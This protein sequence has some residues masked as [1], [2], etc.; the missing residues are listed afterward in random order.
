MGCQPIALK[1]QSYYPVRNMFKNYLI[2]AWREHQKAKGLSSHPGLAVG[3]PI[4]ILIMLSSGPN[5]A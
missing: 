4:F 1:I 5:S 2:I 3:W